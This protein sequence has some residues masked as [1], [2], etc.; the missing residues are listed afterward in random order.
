MLLIFR[1]FKVGDVIEAGSIGGTVQEIGLFTTTINAPD[2]VRIVVPNSAIY[3]QTIKNFGANGT[4]R[5]DLVVRLSYAD[6]IGRAIQTIQ[7]VVS[8][9]PRVLPEPAPQVAVDELGEFSVTVVARP[10]STVENY[11]ALRWDLTRRFKEELM[12]AGCSFPTPP[13]SLRRPFEGRAV[14]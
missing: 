10:W 14:I 8:E 4:R 1:P 6:D 13:P 5:N 11:Q 3:G 12:T 9:D 2:N 7:R